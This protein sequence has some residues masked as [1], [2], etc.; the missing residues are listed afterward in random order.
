MK[1]FHTWRRAS[2]TRRCLFIRRSS[3]PSL[4][5][6][7]PACWAESHLIRLDTDSRVLLPVDMFSTRRGKRADAG[8][9]VTDG[10][11]VISAN[12]ALVHRT[13]L[14][15]DNNFLLG[16]L[17]NDLARKAEDAMDDPDVHAVLQIY[18][19]PGGEVPAH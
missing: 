6:S 3:M 5:G 10:V 7:A 1:Q 18:D 2:S 11:A 8:Y 15:A 17:G 19:S 4:L 16:W 12:G 13:R 9:M 14:D